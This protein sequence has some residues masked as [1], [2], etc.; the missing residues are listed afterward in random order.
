VADTEDNIP[1]SEDAILPDEEPVAAE[2]EPGAAEAREAEPTPAEVEEAKRPKSMF[3]DELA[4]K[5][6]PPLLEIGI[7]IGVPVA[8]LALA[9]LGYLNFSTA[10][11]I[12][13]L[14]L[15]ALMIWMGRKTNTL[16][17]VVL[18]C[19]L[20]ALLGSVYC[21]WTVLA[22]YHF[23]VKAQDAKQRV[24]IAQPVEHHSAMHC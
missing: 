17:T 24:A 18:G 21:L 14:A 2:A 3:D 15:V 7:A 10:L 8:C 12:I 22:K 19:I 23:D 4:S 1:I 5:T 6:P 20:L 16:Y 9:F 13:G 11:L